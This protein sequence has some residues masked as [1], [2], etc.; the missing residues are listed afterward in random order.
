[1]TNRKNALTEKVF[2]LGVDGLDPR[3][4]KKMLRE[5]KMPNLQK[6]ID[7]GSCREDLVLL[8]GHPTVTPPM[9]TTLATGAYPM[10]HGITCFWRNYPGRIDAI[11]YNLDS[12]LCKAEQIWNCTV[13]AGLKTLVFH[14][15]GSSWPPTSD[16]E[17]LHVV[18]SEGNELNDFDDIS[19]KYNSP[20]C[21]L[22]RTKEILPL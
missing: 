5:G 2:I 15:P 1:M 7:R 12:R 9:W 19:L 20:I 8:G 4:S 11:T 10:T 17:Y 13:E 6:F 16:S 14:W 22:S 18:E 3:F 21:V